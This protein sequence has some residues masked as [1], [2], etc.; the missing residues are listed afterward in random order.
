LPFDPELEL[1]IALELALALL[2]PLYA[3]S[4]WMARPE[5]GQPWY[6]IKRAMWRV[7][8]EE[9]RNGL[10]GL[11]LADFVAVVGFAGCPSVVAWRGG[12]LG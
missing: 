5:Y 6:A 3:K 2:P 9:N 7:G 11:A 10:A 4:G 1:E 8:C 12:M